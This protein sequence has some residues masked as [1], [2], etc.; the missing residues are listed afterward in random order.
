MLLSFVVAMAA[1]RV[2]GKGNELP[3]Y[4]PADLRHFKSITLGKM[5]VMGRRTH[6]SI[7]RPLPDRTNIVITR[8]PDYQAPGCTVVH[9]VD[10]A[11]RLAADQE[12][13][14]MIGGAELYRQLLPEV[15]RIYLTEVHADFEG[16]A[17]FPLLAEADW[18]EVEREDC[19]PD[20]RNPWPYSF[21]VLERKA[22]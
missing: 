6:E 15:D 22:A 4:L 12:E 18:N 1:N 13:L 11:M 20:E 8:N 17:R 7:G 16:D 10:E 9:S 19:E 3:W 14:M 2:I 21:V 5:V